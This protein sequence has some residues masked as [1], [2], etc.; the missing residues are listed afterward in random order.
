MGLTQMKNRRKA[1]ED[2]VT[3]TTEIGLRPSESFE[4]KY[5]RLIA[6]R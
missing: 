3:E 4:V 1:S 6:D 5:R 2:E